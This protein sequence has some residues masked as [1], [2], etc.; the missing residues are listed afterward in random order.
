[1]YAVYRKI[2]KLYV[3]FTD[4]HK[5]LSAPSLLSCDT[6]FTKYIEMIEGLV[7]WDIET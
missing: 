5:Y 1:M 4:M 6:L 3:A 2:S 7:L